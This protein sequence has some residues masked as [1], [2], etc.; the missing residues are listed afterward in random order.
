M[1][2]N[3]ALEAALALARAPTLVHAMRRQPLPPGIAGLLRL[4]AVERDPA[5]DTVAAGRMD[6]GATIGWGGGTHAAAPVEPVGGSPPGGEAGH[7]RAAAELYI[8]QVMLFAGAAPHRVLGVAP[9]ASRAEM[10]THLRWLMTWLHPDKSGSDWRSAFASRV[11]QAW[12][13]LS[14]EPPLSR[15]VVAAAARQPGPSHRTTPRVAA[16]RARAP[17]LPWVIHPLERKHA[18]PVRRRIALWAVGL[19]LIALAL[20]TPNHDPLELLGAWLDDGAGQ[21]T[22]DV[23]TAPRAAGDATAGQQRRGAAP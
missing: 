17:R 22:F 1:S 11:L 16:A 7:Q 20:T 9:G 21:D 5:G 23:D 6:L 13:E 10:R 19:V 15:P 3:P 12:H 4:V 2:A 18:R 14:T 8:Q